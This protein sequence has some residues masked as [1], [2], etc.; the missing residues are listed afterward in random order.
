M[1]RHLVDLLS[2][3]GGTTFHS[4]VIAGIGAL[5]GIVLTGL[6][7]ALAF[8]K[9][10]HLPFIVAPM[11]A[12]AVLLFAVP[13]SPFAQPWPIIGGNTISVIIGIAV[14]QLLHEPMAA[15]GA[16][17]GLAVVAMAVARCLHPPGGAAALTAII[18]GPSVAAAG[19]TF[20]LVPVCVNAVLLV[21]VGVA[22]HKFSGHSYP[23]LLAQRLP[24]PAGTA[25]PPP[26]KSSLRSPAEIDSGLHQSGEAH[27][28]ESVG[29]LLLVKEANAVS[30]FLDSAR[31][32]QVMS[33]TLPCVGP[34]DGAAETYELMRQY[35][36]DL[37]PVTASAGKLLG[38]VCSRDIRGK[39]G[40]IGGAITPLPAL[41]P[42]SSLS[43]LIGFF[44]MT[45]KHAV[46]IVDPGDRFL[47]LVTPLDVLAALS[48]DAGSVAR[49]D[50]Q[51]PL[52]ATPRARRL[53]PHQMLASSSNARL[54]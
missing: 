1:K 26:A 52:A 40:N 45:Q 31:C 9:D 39:Q 25:D 21:L 54:S 42:E 53:S 18:G 50:G 2:A 12:S 38:G 11:G 47:G 10:A 48:A 20:A 19:F 22:F 41:Q 44:M 15:A 46:A 49:A 36:V 43:S 4:H 8:G 13:A 6:I 32:E 30:Y 17:V 37:L 34:S 24:N 5:F 23:H 51:D 33:R 27:G 16:A 3:I 7:S 29:R 28:I 14:R 35:G